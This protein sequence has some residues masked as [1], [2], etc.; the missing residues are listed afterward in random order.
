M[1]D[2]LPIQSFGSLPISSASVVTSEF[3]GGGGGMCL[4]VLYEMW[5]QI[6]W[7]L[8]STVA[9]RIGSRGLQAAVCRYN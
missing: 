9:P 7:T 1:G 5:H 3:A 4:R 2:L 6:L 8:D